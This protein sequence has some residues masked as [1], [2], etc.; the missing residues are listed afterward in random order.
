MDSDESQTYSA[1]EP[2]PHQVCVGDHTLG[3]IYWDVARSVETAF[4]YSTDR[5]RPGWKLVRIDADEGE[6]FFL[7]EDDEELL[8]IGDKCLETGQGQ[9][10]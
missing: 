1:G 4:L 8:F 6:E 9:G 10:G 7:S 5:F 2:T 3:V